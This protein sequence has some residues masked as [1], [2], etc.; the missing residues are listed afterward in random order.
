MNL[1][2]KNIAA[3]TPA[4][5][6]TENDEDPEVTAH[7]FNGGSDWYLIEYD[8]TQ[9]LAFG[10]V[11]LNCDFEMSELGYFSIAELENMQGCGLLVDGYLKVIV[12]RDR[13]FKPTPLSK[14]LEDYK[15]NHGLI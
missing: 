15:R 13:Y 9:A 4:F 8:P 11:I 12:E 10:Y 3:V 1:I 6:E 5:Y 7:F 2:T 14:V